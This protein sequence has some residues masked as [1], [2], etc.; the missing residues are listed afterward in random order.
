[1]ETHIAYQETHIAYQV[2]ASCAYE[3]EE[4]QSTWHQNSHMRIE[5]MLQ[6][7]PLERRNT[8]NSNGRHAVNEAHNGHDN[9]GSKLSK[10][11]D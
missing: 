8:T 3:E 11:W 4:E 2:E 6:K 10:N 9:L 5:R 7:L 1:M